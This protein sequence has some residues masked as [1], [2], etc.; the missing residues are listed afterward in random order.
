MSYR[1]RGLSSATFAH[2]YGL[3]EAELARLGAERVIADKPHC[4]PD[5]IE[6][7]DAEPGEALLL[8]NHMHQPAESPYRA[9]HAIFVIEGA[10]RTYDAVG[11][12]PP[13]M[14]HRVLSLRAFDARD[15]IIDGRV[16]PGAEAEPVIEEMLA[17]PNVCYIHA[18]NAGHG[19]YAGLIERA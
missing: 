3:T 7:R 13:V 9:S 16:V 2:L 5:R 18:H 4:Y 6:M 14:R 19:C 11:T 1:I 12:I 8:L 17:N 15:K 10:T